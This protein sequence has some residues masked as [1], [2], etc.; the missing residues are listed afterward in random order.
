[1]TV[2]WR[3]RDGGAR[4]LPALSAL[5][6]VVLS[7]AWPGVGGAAAPRVR[8]DARAT[9]L[10]RAAAFLWAR[11]E[12]DG[13]WRSDRYAVLRSGQ[14]YT[15]FV[16]LALLDVPESVLR[17]PRGGV[18]RA[19]AFIRSRVSDEGCLGASDPDLLEYP[20]YATSY[21]L[22][23]LVRAGDPR[24]R[25]LEA[26]M[27]RWLGSQQFSEANGFS[28]ADQ[29]YGGWGFGGRAP[30]PACPGHMDLAHTRRVLA[31]L[32]ESGWTDAATFARAKVFLGVLQRRPGTTQPPVPAADD[33][34]KGDA[35]FDGGFFFSPLVLNANKG[36]HGTGAGGAFYRSYAT[37]TCDGALALLAA[38]VPEQ[39]ER[40]RAARGWL[41]QHAG[42]E[43]PDGI[44]KGHPEPWY[45]AL[46]FYHLAVRAEASRA[47]GI[48]G[49]WRNGIVRLVS[50][51][52]RGDGS[53]V[54]EESPLMKEDDALLA[55]TLGLIALEAAGEPFFKVR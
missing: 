46:R 32:R 17:R 42:L 53:V 15:P 39:D 36:R 48:P 19:L 18:E 13:G 16:L 47:L 14:A 20:T 3:K 40:V 43:A 23:S 33:P 26:R 21:A 51:G 50:S 52:Q 22:R 10:A 38:G 2:P 9:G 44:P 30:L 5:F 35:P 6:L 31:A 12:K 41:E 25:A 37:A 54:N 11:Q 55:T 29:G 1:M 27:A 7:V 24:D 49:E 4:V 28:P 8:T 34:G 45:S